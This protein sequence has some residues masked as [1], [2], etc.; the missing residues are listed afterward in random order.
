MTNVHFFLRMVIHVL[1]ELVFA[2]KLEFDFLI[3]SKSC[4][5]VHQLQVCVSPGIHMLG[6]R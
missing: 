4:E 6:N 5:G 2:E 1:E 3:N